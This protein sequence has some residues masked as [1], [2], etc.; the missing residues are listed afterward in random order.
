MRFHHFALEVRDLHKSVA[1]YQNFLGFQEEDRMSFMGEEIVFL[2]LEDIRLELI[3][4]T[5]EIPVERNVHLCFEV[6]DLEE[7]LSR[8]KASRLIEGPYNLD[9][10]WKTAFFE[11]P[12]Y[13]V[14]EFLKT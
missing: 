4:S 1:F 10:G 8:F 3:L 6:S 14:L 13:E 5:K 11:G 2:I 9:N 7:V 12:D